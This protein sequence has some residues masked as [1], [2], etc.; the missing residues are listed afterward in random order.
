MEK[1]NSKFEDAKGA[2]TIPTVTQVN[3]WL[4]ADLGRAIACL[5]ALYSDPDLLQAMAVFMHGR[6]VNAAEVKVNP[7]A[8]N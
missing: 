7:Q 8:Q 5:N 6:F 3:E 4:K 2:S 1:S